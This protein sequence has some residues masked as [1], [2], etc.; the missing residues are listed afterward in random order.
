MLRL[1][2][3]CYESDLFFHISTSNYSGFEHSLLD[4]GTNVV[5][6]FDATNG[7]PQEHE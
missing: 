2:P 3:C 5:Q 6:F 4:R 1:E 7:S